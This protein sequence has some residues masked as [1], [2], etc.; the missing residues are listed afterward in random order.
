M[1]MSGGCGPKKKDEMLEERAVAV[2][3]KLCARLST[4]SGRQGCRYLS[5]IGVSEREL[6]I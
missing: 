5:E 2:V 3:E 4:M 6:K 1:A